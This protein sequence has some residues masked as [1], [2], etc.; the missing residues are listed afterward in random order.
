MM[1]TTIAIY[2]LSLLLAIATQAAPLVDSGEEVEQAF[3][4]TGEDAMLTNATSTPAPA[5]IYEGVS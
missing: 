5:T 1:K 3:N 4:Q 2:I